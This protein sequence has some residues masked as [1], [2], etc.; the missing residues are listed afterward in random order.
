MI[1]NAR[2]S[3]VSHLL[4]VIQSKVVEDNVNVINKKHWI[5]KKTLENMPEL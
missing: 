5:E 1:S 3:W 4:P 2:N